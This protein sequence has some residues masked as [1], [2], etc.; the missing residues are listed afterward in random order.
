MLRPT[1]SRPV[2]LG[3]K[4]RSGVEDQIFIALRQL[5]ICLYEEPFLTRGRLGRLQVLLGL[6]SAVIL[7]S[8]PRGTHAFLLN[9]I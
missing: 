8:E 7:G 2:Y 3:V 4:Y 5:R 1:V 6:S 9:N